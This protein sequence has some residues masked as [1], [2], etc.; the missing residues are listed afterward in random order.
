M[1]LEKAWAKVHGS[2]QRIEGG[3]TAEALFALT[4]AYIDYIFHE[5]VK[6]KTVL[7]TRV[8]DADTIGYSIATSASATKTGKHSEQMKSAG[9]IDCHAYSL[10]SAYSTTSSNSEI[11]LVKLRNPWGF[12]E[13]TGAW[14]DND[15]KNW[16]PELKKKFDYQSKDDGIFFMDFSDYLDFYYTTSIC[17]YQAT[18]KFW[19]YSDVDTVNEFA[20]FEFKL[21]KAKDKLK[22]FLAVTQLNSRFKD[23]KDFEYAPL[24]V[25]VAKVVGDQL[26]FIDGDAIEFSFVHLELQGL[27]A[28]K[29]FVFTKPK[30]NKTNK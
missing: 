14:S 16:T 10:I 17:K 19:Y 29:Y 9:I 26:L 6:N 13:W 27:T 12:E 5:Q 15:T 3:N 21:K 30:W 8:L 20:V 1:I 24:Q 4:G 22:L 25:M 7:W 28:G 11:S 18:D 23:S 2:Y